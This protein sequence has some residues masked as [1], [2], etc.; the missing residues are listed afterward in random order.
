MENMVAE[1]A[2]N[3]RVAYGGQKKNNYKKGNNYNKVN[4]KF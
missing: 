2:T 3:S 1:Q 4:I